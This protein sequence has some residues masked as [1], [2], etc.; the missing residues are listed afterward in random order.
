VRDALSN[1][2]SVDRRF[3]SVF[4]FAVFSSRWP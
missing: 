2:G 1:C 4:R 3:F